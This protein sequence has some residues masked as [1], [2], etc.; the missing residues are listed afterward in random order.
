M[1]LENNKVIDNIKK[2]IIYTE[3]IMISIIIISKYI[4]QI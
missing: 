4:M 1:N 3:T 2:G